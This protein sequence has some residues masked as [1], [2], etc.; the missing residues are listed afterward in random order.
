MLISCWTMNNIIERDYVKAIFEYC[1]FKDKSGG[2]DCDTAYIVETKVGKIKQFIEINYVKQTILITE[3]I[4]CYKIRTGAIKYLD[5]KSLENKISVI[6]ETYPFQ[7]DKAYRHE[8]EFRL[9]IERDGMFAYDKTQEYYVLQTDYKPSVEFV[10]GNPRDYLVNIYE[11]NK[12]TKKLVLKEIPLG[13]GETMPPQYM[14]PTNS[15]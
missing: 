1:N 4:T 5:V 14:K 9:F 6:W 8:N 12:R 10:Q 15:Y 3:S 13:Q 11:Y 7:K 2:K